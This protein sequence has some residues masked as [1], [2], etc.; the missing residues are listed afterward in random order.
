MRQTR[1]A[2]ILVIL[3]MILT[4][5]PAAADNFSFSITNT[6]G[7]VGGTVTGEI[8]GL[9]N[10][11]FSSATSV[12]I[13]TFPA[14]LNSIYGPGPIDATLWDQQSQNSFD[15]E[16]GVVVGGGFWAQQPLGTFP[17]GAQLYINGDFQNGFNFVNLD[18]ND[19]LFVWGDPGL[20]QA[21]IQAE[22]D[23]SVPEPGSLMLLG[24]ALLGVGRF[25]RRKNAA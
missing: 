12:L 11:G 2:L 1:T 18:G 4:A 10:G 20:G 14:G 19:Q 23:T 7:T 24:T 16:G 22:S 17:A 8:L 9:T 25:L 3:A 15:E 6:I 21:N 5:L 13:E